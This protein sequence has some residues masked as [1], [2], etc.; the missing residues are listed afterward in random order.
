MGKHHQPKANPERALI[1][2][3]W[4][5]LSLTTVAENTEHKFMC[6]GRLSVTNQEGWS[7]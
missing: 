7:R 2:W 6:S 1:G 5:W 4:F 3:L